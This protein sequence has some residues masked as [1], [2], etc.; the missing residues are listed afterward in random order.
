M[1]CT[2]TFDVIGGHFIKLVILVVNGA[3]RY[4]SELD[5]ITL[6]NLYSRFFFPRTFTHSCWFLVQGTTSGVG[7]HQTL[8][9]L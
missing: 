9:H 6:L 3:I 2:V 7:E 5:S 4:A 8:F 1:M